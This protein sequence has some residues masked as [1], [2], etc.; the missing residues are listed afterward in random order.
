[1]KELKALFCQVCAACAVDRNGQ[2]SL[3][4]QQPYTRSP[5]DIT[6]V[7]ERLS[8]RLDQELFDDTLDPP[9]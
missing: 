6:A 8:R 4:P 9:S 2:G 1:M 5:Y 7:V 3:F